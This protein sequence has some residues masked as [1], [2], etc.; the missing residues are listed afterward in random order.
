MYK[1]QGRVKG[2]IGRKSMR[3][4][5]ILGTVWKR[6]KMGAWC[7]LRTWTS[8]SKIKMN[9]TMKW[10]R[11]TWALETGLMICSH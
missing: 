1:R 9:S 3:V 4:L 8:R 6:E 11:C 5:G 7:I 2:E 10:Q